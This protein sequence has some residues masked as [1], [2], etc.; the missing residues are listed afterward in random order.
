[1]SLIFS[2][3]VGNNAP[4][5]QVL[6]LA[7]SSRNKKTSRYICGSTSVLEPGLCTCGN[8]SCRKYPHYEFLFLHLSPSLHAAYPLAM[9]RRSKTASVHVDRTNSLII[10]DRCCNVP[11][12]RTDTVE[13]NR[14][15]YYCAS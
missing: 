5:I 4:I 10:Q 15:R 11:K 1:M 13:N 9:P 7:T 12:K 2:N 8:V 3:V 14:E 6:E